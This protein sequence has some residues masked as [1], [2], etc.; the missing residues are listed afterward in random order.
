MKNFIFR[1]EKA[2]K[3]KVLHEKIRENLLEWVSNLEYS[4][5]A[6]LGKILF[7]C[8]RYNISLDYLFGKKDKCSGYIEQNLGINI[9][10]SKVKIDSAYRSRLASY[11]TKKIEQIN[12]KTLFKY[13]DLIERD[14]YEIIRGK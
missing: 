12:I 6:N 1:F 8:R 10:I 2:L 4:S 13:A 11:N 7:L 9:D 5:G 3:C 14:P